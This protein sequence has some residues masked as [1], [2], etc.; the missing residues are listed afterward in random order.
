MEILDGYHARAQVSSEPGEPRWITFCV[1]H[2]ELC[3]HETLTLAR[4]H[5]A[6]PQEWCE[7]CRHTHEQVTYSE[8]LDAF[9]AGDGPDPR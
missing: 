3:Q 1:T 5:A 9:L 7:S 2:G 4:D 6:A 8:R